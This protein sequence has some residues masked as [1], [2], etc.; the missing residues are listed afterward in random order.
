MN[1]ERKIFF[2]RRLPEPKIMEQIELDAFGEASV[3]NYK[4]WLIPLVDEAL[5]KQ[6]C[7]KERSLIL[8]KL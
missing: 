6:I 2:P 7:K 3:A 1:R 5:G 4:R 8:H